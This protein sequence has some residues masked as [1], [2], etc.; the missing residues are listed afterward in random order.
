MRSLILALAHQLTITGTQTLNSYRVNVRTNGG[1][2]LVVNLI[3]MPG[4]NENNRKDGEIFLVEIKDMLSRHGAGANRKLSGVIYMHDICIPFM[5]GSAKDRLK[6]FRALPHT[7]G[8]AKMENVLLV[9]N[10]WDLVGGEEGKG[11][12][13]DIRS[14]CWRTMHKL[15]SKVE[16][17]DGT[18]ESGL[19]L[20]QQLVMPEDQ[21]PWEFQ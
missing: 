10:R 15:G 13:E 3:D 7:T 4:F 2:V 21:G 20:L 5:Y 17:F 16:R 8:S 12:E 9:T 14:V 11:F 1:K 6:M 18:A 19:K